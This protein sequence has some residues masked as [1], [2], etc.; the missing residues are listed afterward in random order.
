M[1]G[2]EEERGEG[3]RCVGEKIGKDSTYDGSIEGL[4]AYEYDTCVY[5]SALYV[6]DDVGMFGSSR[7][8]CVGGS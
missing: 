7:G 2:R 3:G 4:L 6:C 1:A 8:V 5:G